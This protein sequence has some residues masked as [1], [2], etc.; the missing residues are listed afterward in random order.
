V[1]KGQFSKISLP[2]FSA[3]VIGFL[4]G[5]ILEQITALNYKES[6]Q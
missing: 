5:V 3:A 2:V 4:T 6:S 1:T